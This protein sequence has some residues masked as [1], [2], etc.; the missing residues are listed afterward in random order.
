M[1]TAP[2]HAVV[3]LA[4]G[5][6]FRRDAASPTLLGLGALYSMLPDL[7]VIGLRLGIAFFAP[8]LPTR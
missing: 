2:T 8:V 5:A 6:G 3:A 1:P 7:D 4:L